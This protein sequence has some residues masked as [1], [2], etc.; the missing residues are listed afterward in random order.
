MVELDVEILL[1]MDAHRLRRMRVV[2][3]DH[4]PYHLLRLYFHLRLNL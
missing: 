3:H 1:L 2:I 4:L